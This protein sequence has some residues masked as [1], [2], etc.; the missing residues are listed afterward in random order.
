[1]KMDTFDICKLQNRMVVELKSGTRYMYINGSLYGEEGY[2]HNLAGKATSFSKFLVKVWGKQVTLNLDSPKHL[3]W[4]RPLEK[5]MTI[6][7]IEKELGY[8]I[9]IVN[10]K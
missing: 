2:I 5:E 8:K 10:N 4:E 3:I 6:E 1:M 9:K 7:D